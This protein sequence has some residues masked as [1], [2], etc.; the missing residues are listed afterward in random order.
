MEAEDGAKKM[1]RRALR[2]GAKT[3]K[4]FNKFDEWEPDDNQHSGYLT[5]YK[6]FVF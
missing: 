3:P 1:R 2:A 4:A 6:L 5:F